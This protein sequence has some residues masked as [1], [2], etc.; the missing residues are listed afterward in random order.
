MRG[1]GLPT[2]RARARPKVG[3]RGKGIVH[4]VINT[5]HEQLKDACTALVCISKRELTLA[6][7]LIGKGDEPVVRE[8][9]PFFDP[10]SKW[11]SD[12]Q[13]YHRK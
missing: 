7:A 5:R 3:G 1:P 9:P 10:I 4:K 13:E 8:D 2:S 11:P 12:E 6:T